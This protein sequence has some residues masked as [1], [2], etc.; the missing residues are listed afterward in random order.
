MGNSVASTSKP[1][2]PP[3]GRKLGILGVSL[4]KA[5]LPAECEAVLAEI[6]D[7]LTSLMETTGY[8]EQAPFSW[9]TVALRFGLKDDAEPKFSRVNAKSGDLPLAIELDVS[10]L[11]SESL[12]AYRVAYRRAAARALLSAGIRYKLS[13]QSLRALAALAESQWPSQSCDA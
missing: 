2:S 5:R 7:E 12:H 9:V 3:H 4:T 8:L 10:A 6:R 13:I 1:P 11:H